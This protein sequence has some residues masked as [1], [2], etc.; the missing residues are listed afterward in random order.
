MPAGLRAAPRARKLNSILRGYTSLSS[1]EGT[2]PPGR[3]GGHARDDAGN[4]RAEEDDAARAAHVEH[5]GDH[6]ERKRA[7][8]RRSTGAER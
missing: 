3:E 8:E 6:E 7:V 4:P 1:S 2:L 5:A